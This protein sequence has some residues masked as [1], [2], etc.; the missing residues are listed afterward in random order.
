MNYRDD[1]KYISSESSVETGKKSLE[2]LTPAPRSRLST[3]EERDELVASDGSVYIPA[4]P[5][6]LKVR[7]C[8]RLDRR[9]EHVVIG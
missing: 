2:R 5:Q 1:E 9:L 6:R 8:S 3:S 7:T 4:Y